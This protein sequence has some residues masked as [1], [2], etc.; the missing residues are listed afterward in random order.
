MIDVAH[1]AR[2]TI[3]RRLC[4]LLGHRPSWVAAVALGYMDRPVCADCGQVLDPDAAAI[5]GRGGL[6]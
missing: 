5:D 2:L 6:Q 3:L 4:G 1:R